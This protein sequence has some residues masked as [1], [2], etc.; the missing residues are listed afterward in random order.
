MSNSNI[1]HNKFETMNTKFL[2]SLFYRLFAFSLL[3]YKKYMYKN[4]KK[5]LQNNKTR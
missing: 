3:K 2:K 1:L 4:I 5:I